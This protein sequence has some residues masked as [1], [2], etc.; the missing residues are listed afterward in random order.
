MFHVSLKKKCLGDYSLIV[1]TE[2]IGIKNNLSDEEVPVKNLNRQLRKL[3]TK[4]VALTSQNTTICEASK[5]YDGCRDKT[6]DHPNRQKIKVKCGA[7]QKAMRLTNQTLGLQVVSMECLLMTLVTC[8]Y[9]MK[10]VG[11]MAS[12]HRMYELQGG[13]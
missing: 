7:L 11:Q 4:E 10:D 5:Y 8:I 6:Q 2:N 12:V 1:P 9:I 3:R 13:L